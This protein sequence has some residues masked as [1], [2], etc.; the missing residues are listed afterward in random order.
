MTS[1]DRAARPVRRLAR[2][3]PTLA[4]LLGV[5]LLVLPVLQRQLWPSA[6]AGIRLTVVDVVLTVVCAVALAFRRRHPWPVLAVTTVATCVAILSGHQANLAQFGLSVAI[7][8]VALHRPRPQVLVAMAI[9]TVT[10]QATSLLAAQL[11]ESTWRREDVILWVW[12][13]TA[14]ALAVQSHR[15]TTLALRERARRAE[16]T[17]EEI[18]MRRVAEER[19]RI[20]RDLHDVIAHHVAVISVQSGV[21]QHVLGR[22][23]DA[24]REALTHVRTSARSVLSELQDVLS[25]LRGTDGEPGTAP[26]PGLADVPALV[27][28]ARD[29]GL[30][31]ELDTA[32]LVPADLSTADP[33]AAVAMTAYRIVQEALTNVRKHAPHARARVVL[34]SDEDGMLVRVVNDA[35][36][37]GDA[38]LAPD[39][40]RDPGSQPD[41]VAGSHLG[42][43]GMRERVAAVGGLLQV[44]PRPDGGFSVTARFPAGQEEHR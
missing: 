14:T 22:D 42:L 23:E 44:G 24:A 31:V 1:G 2:S 20:A 10:F 38:G 34:R 7:V 5:A 43:V 18:A 25:V 41:P 39:L 30:A 3:E 33:G 15:A 4:V 27:E 28:A 6:G 19:L 40:D 11:T 37:G 29:A 13:V 17:R 16:E 36:T 26:A 9:A 12:V 35:P 8:S 21:A 32:G